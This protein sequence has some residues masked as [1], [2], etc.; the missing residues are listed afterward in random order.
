[1]NEAFSLKKSLEGTKQVWRTALLCERCIFFRI[2]A[3]GHRAHLLAIV[4]RQ[5]TER[6]PTNRVRLLKDRVEYRGEIARRRI[7]DTQH[8]CGRCLLLQRLA[9]LADKLPQKA[10]LAGAAR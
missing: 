10:A 9:R 1:M 2:T 4:E 3:C 6:G 7:D 5:A 8:L